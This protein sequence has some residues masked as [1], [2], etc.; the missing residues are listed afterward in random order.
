MFHNFH[1]CCRL[2]KRK[3]YNISSACAT[4]ITKCA[5]KFATE[6][7]RE[8]TMHALKLLDVCLRNEESILITIITKKRQKHKRQDNCHKNYFLI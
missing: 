3:V 4:A 6:L 7:K 8:P 5:P 1:D 2:E